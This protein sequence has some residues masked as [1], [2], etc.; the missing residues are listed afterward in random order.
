MPVVFYP[1][2]AALLQ[3]QERRT[4]YAGGEIRLF[5]SGFVPTPSDPIAAYTAE[6]ADFTNYAAITVAAW[7]DPILAPNS[8]YLISSPYFQFETGATDPTTAN[9]IG[10]LWYED[11]TSRIRMT[12]I[13]DE[14]LPMQV[15]N[16][17]IY[18]TLV[19]LF[20]TLAS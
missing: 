9:T 13:F 5:Q 15:A 17:G 19:D 4:A 1:M 8:G 14:A 16:Q 20:P 7:E 10:G 18:G 6:E 11:A 3:A 12:I 2:S